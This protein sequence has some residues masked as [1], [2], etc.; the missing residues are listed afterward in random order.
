MQF[1]TNTTLISIT[2]LLAVVGLQFLVFWSRDRLSPWL[3]WFGCTFLF[4]AAGLLVYLLP[5]EG[6]EFLHYGCGNALR[7]AAFAFLWQDTRVFC[8]RRK[9]I[10]AIQTRG[11]PTNWTRSPPW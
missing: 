2:T 10:K 11:S 3:G 5:L 8:T 1:D 4:F 9:I 6:M 7:L